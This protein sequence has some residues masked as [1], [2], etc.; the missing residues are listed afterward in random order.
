MTS[1]GRAGSPSAA[2]PHAGKSL[3]A[4]TLPLP[5]RVRM[6]VDDTCQA[7]QMRRAGRWEL[8]G[9][10]RPNSPRVRGVPG[11]AAA[12]G[13]QSPRALSGCALRRRAP[14]RV[15]RQPRSPAA[16]GAGVPQSAGIDKVALVRLPSPTVKGKEPRAFAARGLRIRDS[17]IRRFGILGIRDARISDS[18]SV[19]S[20]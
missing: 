6:R 15:G 18:R 12:L 1:S 2:A 20:D 19:I 5:R 17:R 11:A 3:A 16:R 10:Q 14:H 8:R 13:C 7:H 9:S 4:H